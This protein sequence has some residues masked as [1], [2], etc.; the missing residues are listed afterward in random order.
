MEGVEREATRGNFFTE[1][2][3]KFFFSAQA[4]RE[5]NPARY[6]YDSIDIHDGS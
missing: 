5:K 2:L 6:D 1:T 4:E 3:K